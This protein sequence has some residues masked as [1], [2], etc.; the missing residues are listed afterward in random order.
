MD[1]ATLLAEWMHLAKDSKNMHEEAANFSK[2]WADT[3]MLT[4]IILSSAG[5]GLNIILGSVDPLAFVFAQIGLGVVVL[6]ST[7]IITISKELKLEELVIKHQE[8]SAR[9]DDLHRVIQAELVLLRMNDSSYASR[10]DFLKIIE[11]ELRKIQDAAPSPPSC[12]AKKFE[13]PCTPASS[14]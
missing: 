11:N 3:C 8:Y 14:V 5:G 13:K 9:F 2:M 1:S 10:E 4:G 6:T 7:A 12:I